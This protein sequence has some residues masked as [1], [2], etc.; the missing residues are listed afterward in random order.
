MI[1]CAVDV[2]F[3][4]Y[5][6]TLKKKKKVNVLNV[7]KIRI[8]NPKYEYRNRVVPNK[9]KIQMFKIQNKIAKLFAVTVFVL[10]ILIL[11]I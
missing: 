3:Y 11:V 7:T 4:G 8:T 1:E 10:V 9:S 6:I 5:Y 2:F